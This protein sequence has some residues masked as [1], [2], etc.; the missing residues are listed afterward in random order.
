MQLELE[1]AIAEVHPVVTGL[2]FVW[3]R[4]HCT[5]LRMHL[6][7]IIFSLQTPSTTQ[8]LWDC[9]FWFR[10]VKVCHVVSVAPVETYRAVNVTA[11]AAKDVVQQICNDSIQRFRNAV[12]EAK[13][14]AERSRAKADLLEDRPCPEASP[15]QNIYMTTPL[16]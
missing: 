1:A 14:V 16:P 8:T 3:R 10:I 9:R 7:G 6:R 12:D 4:Y 13:A 2:V 11:T 15:Y 5:L